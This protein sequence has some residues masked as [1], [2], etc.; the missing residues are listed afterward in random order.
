MS[1]GYHTMQNVAAHGGAQQARRED[2]SMRRPLPPPPQKT[3]PSCHFP[4]PQPMRVYCQPAA[5]HRV[6]GQEY[7]NMTVAY[8]Q[9]RQLERYY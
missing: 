1:N 9:S 8:G 7:Q 4:E 6:N 3:Q 5:F 2:F